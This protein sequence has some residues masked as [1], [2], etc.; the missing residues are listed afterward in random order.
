[1]SF[2]SLFL[3]TAV[4][5][6]SA[7]S[8]NAGQ[9]VV[10]APTGFFAPGQAATTSSPYY[11]DGGEDWGWTHGALADQ[12]TSGS[13]VAV[14]RISAFDVDAPRE[15]D[16]IYFGTNTSGVL[17]GDL[18]GNNG[19]YA[20]TDFVITDPTMLAAIQAGTFSLFMD[21]DAVEQVNWLVTLGRSVLCSNIRDANECVANP[22]PGEVPEPITL[23]LF[24][25]GLAGAA[26]LRRRQSKK[27]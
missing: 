10:E 7:V 14:L 5:A 9:D 19:I 26:A 21:I 27:A 11:R 25:A 4:L 23:T 12:D 24:G 17:L 3:A 16:N 1:M 13:G 8:A 15:V 2:K 22:N 6:V 20:F 18:D